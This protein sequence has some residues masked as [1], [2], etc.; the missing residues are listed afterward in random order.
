MCKTEEENE[1]VVE[2]KSERPPAPTPDE[3]KPTQE[4][5]ELAESPLRLFFYFMPPRLWR[6][7]ATESNRYYHQ[8][9]NERLSDHWAT[10]AVRAIPKG[11]FGQF[12]SKARFDWIMQNLHFTDNTD[13]R[14]DTDRAWKVRSV[15][16]TLQ[17]TFAHGYKVPPV[18]SLDEAMIPSRSRHN[19]TRQ[20][21]KDKPH[22]WGTK[23]FMTC[24]A[25]KTYCL[26]YDLILALRHGEQFVLAKLDMLYNTYTS[27]C[28][29]RIYNI[30]A[31]KFFV[32]P[33]STLTSVEVLRPHSTMRTPILDQLQ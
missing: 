12:V 33:S 30:T 1:T 8:H 16:E 21:M 20:F 5:L 10:T 11:T 13:A 3:Y 9:L 24:C 26:R 15:V 4:T 14:S 25:E 6:R 32:V 2:D 27:N 7:I 22:K 19:I 17:N 18:L 31:L 29:W 28:V 23:V